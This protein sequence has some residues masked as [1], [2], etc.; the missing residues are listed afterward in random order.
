MTKIPQFCKQSAGLIRIDPDSIAMS[1][2]PNQTFHRLFDH[3]HQITSVCWNLGA[4]KIRFISSL[5]RRSRERSVGLHTQLEIVAFRK[6][7]H[8]D[9]VNLIIIIHSG[10][11]PPLTITTL[12]EKAEAFVNAATHDKT[13]RDSTFKEYENFDVKVLQAPQT[14]EPHQL[15]MNQQQKTTLWHGPLAYLSY[16]RANSGLYICI[17][18][19]SKKV[20]SHIAN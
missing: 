17:S 20:F 7:R 10:K 9:L 4:C 16:I 2:I 6:K 12:I 8:L 15:N 14:M 11:V 1:I 18:V 3:T 19:W 5:S 13:M